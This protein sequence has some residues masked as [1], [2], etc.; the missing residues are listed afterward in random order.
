MK[1]LIEPVNQGVADP[2]LT[3]WLLR[4]NYKYPDIISF[5]L[6]LVNYLFNFYFLCRYNMLLFTPGHPAF[7]KDKLLMAGFRYCLQIYS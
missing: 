3:T 2:C 1:P 5:H 6:L 7:A 4:L